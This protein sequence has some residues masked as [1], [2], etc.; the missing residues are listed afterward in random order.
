MSGIWFNHTLICGYWWKGFFEGNC[1]DGQVNGNNGC[2]AWIRVAHP[3]R[4]KGGQ[5]GLEVG[6]AEIVKPYDEEEDGNAEKAGG[7]FAAF[8]GLV[9]PVHNCPAVKIGKKSVK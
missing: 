2:S 5:S 8:L 4:R 3:G 9:V 7:D 6:F 1:C